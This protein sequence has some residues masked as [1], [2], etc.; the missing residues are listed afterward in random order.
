MGWSLQVLV[1]VLFLSGI[2]MVCKKSLNHTRFV[3]VS[4]HRFMNSICY[5]SPRYFN[6]CASVLSIPSDLLI[7]NSVLAASTSSFSTS[8]SMSSVLSGM[9]LSYRSLGLFPLIYRS[10]TCSFHWP[11][12]SLASCRI[13]SC[14]SLTVI[15]FPAFNFSISALISVY[16]G[17]IFQAVVMLLD[18]YI[19]NHTIFLWLHLLLFAI[20]C[21]M[22]YTTALHL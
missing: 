15:S 14:L 18:L 22:L 21:L 1:F 9:H 8:G 6:I 5:L 10:I 12:T 16:P 13:L 4:W 19:V 11:V 2:V 20:S 7:F 3:C 17:H